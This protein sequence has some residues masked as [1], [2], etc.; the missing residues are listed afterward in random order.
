MNTMTLE[1]RSSSLEEASP[2]VEEKRSLSGGVGTS[3]LEVE[4]GS[5]GST[6]ESRKTI[7]VLQLAVIVFYN[8]SGK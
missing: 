3:P 7:G 2:E 5:D 6:N 8:V 1:G 4:T